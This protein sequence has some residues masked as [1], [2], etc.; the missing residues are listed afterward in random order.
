MYMYVQNTYNNN[1]RNREEKHKGTGIVEFMRH[2]VLVGFLRKH[3]ES[4]FSTIHCYCT[5]FESTISL[6]WPLV[7]KSILIGLIGHIFGGQ[8]ME[9]SLCFKMVCVRH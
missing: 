5:V 3:T 4:S 7:K 1:M 2:P 8:S 9:E 6:N